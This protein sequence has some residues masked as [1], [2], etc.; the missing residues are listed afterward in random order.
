[1][2]YSHRSGA[3]LYR[4]L[5]RENDLLGLRFSF[6]GFRSQAFSEGPKLL[7]TKAEPLD[8]ANWVSLWHHW[9]VQPPRMTMAEAEEERNSTVKQMMVV[10]QPEK[11]PERNKKEQYRLCLFHRL[12]YRRHVVALCARE[13]EKKLRGVCETF[14]ERERENGSGRGREGRVGCV[15]IYTEEKQKSCGNGV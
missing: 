9:S 7:R 15:E 8:P 5:Q 10:K 1:M 3:D 2:R 6:R 14:N 4:R 11:A 12:V 13:R